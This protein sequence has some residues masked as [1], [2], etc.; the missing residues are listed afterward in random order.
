MEK[1]LILN[2]LDQIKTLADPLRLRI[3]EAMT[4][5]PRTTRQVA[6]Q[7]GEKPNRL[8]HHV[9]ALE[10]AGL[11]R[12][13]ET[14]PNRGTLEKYYQAAAD[15]FLVD[16]TVFA[17]Q[18]PGGEGLQA[19][20]GTYTSLFQNAQAELL[21]AAAAADARGEGPGTAGV[22]QLRVRASQEKIDELREM[23][24]ALAAAFQEANDPQGEAVLQPVCRPVP[25]PGG[26]MMASAEARPQPGRPRRPGQSQLPPA[27]AGTG[28]LADRGCGRQ[29]DHPD[30]DQPA[31]RFDRR[32]GRADDR[33]GAA[34]P[35]VWAGSR[36][37]RRPLGPAKNPDRFGRAARA[38]GPGIYRRPPA[39]PGLGVLRAR[40]RAG[41]RQHPVRPGQERAD[42]ADP[43]PGKPAG[44]QRPLPDDPRPGGRFRR[45]PGRPAGRPGGQ[46]LAVLQPG[47]PLLSDFRP[48]H[49]PDRRAASKPAPT[50]SDWAGAPGDRWWTACGLPS[51]AGCW[52]G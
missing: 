37:F 28:D 6:R 24:S 23:F 2:Q 35:P 1:T 17:G 20:L 26:S 51:A 22:Y 19:V 3:L 27:V 38:A 45:S 47:F 42:P 43:A 48:V 30:P 15:H 36:R 14:R 49:L 33:H 16:S 7:L 29:P 4:A 5:S 8:Y 31:H 9:E 12:L 11:I 44:G 25:R 52:S 34:D 39:G 32:A 21:A 18:A 46:R 50:R 13:V 41:R 40:F 10:K